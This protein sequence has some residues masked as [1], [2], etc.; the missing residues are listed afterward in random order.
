[1]IAGT[2]AGCTSDYLD[3]KPVTSI[4]SATIETTQEGAQAAVYGLC[5]AM[6]TIYYDYASNI[7]PNGEGSLMVF[8]GD[9]MGQ[10]YFSYFYSYR[11]PFVMTMNRF[12]DNQTWMCTI[13]WAYCYNLISQANTI[14]QGI[15][16]IE[17]DKDVLQF[18]KAEAL[19][20]RAHAYFRLLQLYA[21]RWEDSNNGEKK[22]IVLRKT[23]G[24]Y[25]APL[26]TMNEVLALIKDDLT[27]AIEIFDNNPTHRKFIWEPDEDVARGIYARTALLM[28]DF[29]TAQV[30][31]HESRKNNRYPIMSADEY[32]GGFAEVNDEY[33]W[34]NA[35]DVDRLGYWANGAWYACQ[36]AYVDWNNGVGTINYEL[37]RQI[38]ETDIRRDLFFTPDKLVG[39]TISKAA[40]WNENICNPATMN[41][42]KNANMKNQYKAFGHRVIPDGDEAK[43]SQPYVSRQPGNADCDVYFGSQYKF[44]SLDMYGTDSWPFMRGAEMLLSEAEAACHNG[45]DATAKALLMELNAKRN[46]NYTCNKTGNALLEEVKLQRRIELWGEGHNFFDLKR[47][48]EPLVRNVWERGNMNSNNIPYAYRLNL[49]PDEQNGWV[50]ILPLRETQFNNA[51]DLTEL[52]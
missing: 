24:T 3:V 21:P 23:P 39:T 45:D 42:S 40:F 33:M 28:H 31:A 2:L 26:S 51:I 17:G 8:Y 7:Q 25:D 34:A 27:E 13:P 9:V 6:A 43:W 4:S 20:I 19:S 37:Y 49:Q 29:E 35:A 41:L 14:L 52:N 22:C 32:K 5:G 47:W 50:W 10:D 12:R 48:N 18:I 36:G 1:M 38:P 44:W 46:P 30:M 11:A 16:E 15:D